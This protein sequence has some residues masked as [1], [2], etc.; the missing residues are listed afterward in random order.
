VAEAVLG[1]L[2]M[3]L[4]RGMLDGG[5]GDTDVVDKAGNAVA[6]ATGF[7]G[8]LSGD[9]RAEGEGSSDETGPGGKG[10]RDGPTPQIGEGG[11]TC[12][13]VAEVVADARGL[14]FFLAGAVLVL[15]DE[16]AFFRLRGG[17]V[18]LIT[19]GGVSR[20]GGGSGT[21]GKVNNCCSC[22]A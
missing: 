8:R 22:G 5:V 15:P 11:G 20:A 4:E 10:A 17:A 16:M 9:G 21:E 14:R 6:N 7:G 2:L 19:G 12:R 3:S 13:L 1:A 18:T